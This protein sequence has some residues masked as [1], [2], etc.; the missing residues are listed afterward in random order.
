MKRNKVDATE[1]YK[2]TSILED[3]LKKF[4]FPEM[5]IKYNGIEYIV[6]N[7][8]DYDEVYK[9]ENQKFRKLIKVNGLISDIYIYKNKFY[10]VVRE[11]DKSYL[12]NFDENG[13]SKRIS[14]YFLDI[15]ELQVND[16][17]KFK[18]LTFENGEYLWKG[19]ILEF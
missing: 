12:I 10:A 18:G 9:F 1:L 17:I 4:C 7:L 14:D 6:V 19:V 8:G 13:K 16:K 2:L 11:I 3:K 15:K 5:G